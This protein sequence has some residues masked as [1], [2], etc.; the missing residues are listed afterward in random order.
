MNVRKLRKTVL[1]AWLAAGGLLGSAYAGTYTNDFN[2]PDTTG[3]I[4]NG[5]VR[6]DGTT[7]YPAI[8]G[9]H[10]A[11]VYAENSKQGS[12]VF[13]NLDPGKA[14]E[15]FKMNFKLRIGGGSST[16][17][18]GLAIFLGQVD[19]AINF[20]EEGPDA[21]TYP[22]GL[23][24]SFDIYDNGG[25]EAPAIDIK[26]NGVTIGHITRTIF[27]IL[28]EDF[29]PVSIELKKNGTLSLSYKGQTFYTDVWLPGYAPVAG[30]RFVIGARTGGLNANQWI[31][32]IGITTVQAVPVAPSITTPPANL[33]INERATATFS[34]GFAGSA[35]IA[36]QW[37]SNNVEIAD[38]TGPVLNLTNVSA[39]ANGAKFKVTATNPAGTVT[40]SEAIL[41]VNSDTTKPTIISVAGNE[42]FNGV[43][44]T[45][46]EPVSE[47]TASVVGN[48]SIAGLS[49]SGVTVLSP[50]QVLLATAHQTAGASYTVTVNGIQDTALVANTIA[51]NTTANFKAFVLSP[52]FLKWE[53]WGNIG[54][55]TV[56]LLQADPRFIANTPDRTEYLPGFDSRLIFPDD[57]VENYGTR[58][59]G[60]IVPTETASYRFFITSDDSSQ[61]S[62]STDD[63]PANL[64]VIA[65]EPSCCNGFTEPGT[66]RTSDPIALEAGKAYYVEALQ[67]EGGGGDYIQVAWRKEGDTTAANLL[68]PIPASFLAVNADPGPVTIVFTTQPA[69]RTSAENTKAT[70][71]AGATG[72]PAPLE[73]QWQRSVGGGAFKDIPGATGTSYTTPILKQNIDN[74]AKYRVSARVPGGS[75]V[76]DEATLTVIIDSTPPQLLSA[77]GGENQKSVVL[78]FSEEVDA[79][80][81]ATA[82]NYTISGLTVSGS[83][84]LGDTVVLTTSPQTA[85]HIYTVTVAGVKDSALNLVDPAHNT[86][87]FTALAIQAGVLKYQAYYAIQGTAYTD[88]TGAA[89]YPNSPDFTQLLG[90]FEAPN[91][92]GDQY[93][94]RLTG[95]VTPPE[96]GDYRFFISS[97]DGSALYVS[98]DDSPAHL[99][100][101]PSA[102]ELGCCNPFQ[103]PD[104]SQTSAPLHLEQG[105][106]YYVVYLLKEGGGGDNG[107]VGWRE[108]G[109]TTGAST[110]PSIPGKYLAAA[111]TPAQLD[112]FSLHN[113]SGLGTGNADKPGFKA[114][115][116]QIDQAGGV[117][118]AT[119]ID[120]AE[121]QLAGL[122]GPNVADLSTAVD[123]IFNITG[124]INFNE[125][126]SGG[127]AGDFQSSSDPARPDANIPGIPGLGTATAHN[128]DNIAGEFITYVEF[129]TAG[130]YYM[131]VNS[132]DGFNVTATDT[133]PANYGA[134]VVAAPSAAAG[135][136][137]IL[138]PGLDGSA[139]PAISGPIV[140][141][142]VYAT[143]PDGCSAITN[144]DAIRGNI[145]LID[146]G[147]C[148]FTAKAQ[149][150]KDAG[151]IAVIIVN[152]RDPGSSDGPLPSNMGGTFLD[153]P[154]FMISKPDGAILKAALGTVMN[155]SI[156]PDPTPTLGQFRTG[157]GSSD[158]IFPVIVP[159]AGVFPMRCVWFEGGGGANVEWFSVNADG[160]KV[161]LNDREN[162]SALKTYAARTVAVTPTISIAKA[163]G[164]VTITFTGHLYASDAVT[165]PYTLVA[166][167]GS[168]TVSATGT[169]KFYRSGP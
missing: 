9:G 70:F 115:I 49:I 87:S 65:S 109:D 74:G 135:K 1:A 32:D 123:G 97:D 41:T 126:P 36:F 113:G 20:G 116:H 104:A 147:V 101:T 94:A 108:E 84:V 19:D 22:N 80:T 89:K 129:P 57:S 107:R 17:A 92:F 96:T 91:T 134:L 16:P 4:L 51:A 153:F 103:E 83:T 48:Y 52:G 165:G 142:L 69:S 72:S 124:V 63:S 144:P 164:G 8:E 152:S 117:T 145:A 5:G 122:L 155:I 76:S 93:G 138:D 127:E 143:P 149:A 14:I 111:L 132:D 106:L 60:F 95:F 160:T 121:Q 82:A 59:S 168:V 78:R 66:T 53:Y 10:L 55:T 158:T 105:K 157:R 102:V 151:A 29:N 13:P 42:S 110:L 112:S 54:G 37:L 67:K 11:L 25:G 31:D 120:R 136:Y 79:T 38:A 119:S 148:T 130:V 39:S 24:V 167:E 73:L 137:H 88:L 161:L 162:P 47:A 154:A 2:N 26:V 166:G 46:S 21:A 68:K 3:L 75:L 61:L 44:V 146:R 131:G 169:S 71:T 85:G 86:A 27:E 114:R 7:P 90:Q 150:A 125:N 35:P 159:S 98:T 133:A 77:S 28:S 40:S 56:D 156:T 12:V 50:T 45:F 140:G 18:D 62:L 99:P 34:V 15:S 23:T 43:V 139:F 6:D 163:A 81:A 64:A 128:L 33:S 118:A 30:D 141:K 100:A 58:I